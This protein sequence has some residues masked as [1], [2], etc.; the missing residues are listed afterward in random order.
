MGYM[1]CM[2]LSTP[3]ATNVVHLPPTF[4]DDTLSVA[5]S[6]VTITTTTTSSTSQGSD[7]AGDVG[8]TPTGGIRSSSVL[9][10]VKRLSVDIHRQRTAQSTP[11]TGIYYCT[12]TW[13]T[14]GLGVLGGGGAFNNVMGSSKSL[15]LSACNMHIQY[16]IICFLLH[17]YMYMYIHV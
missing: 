1:Y 11:S 15:Y 3:V 9:P 2:Q 8:A 10:V 16:V 13:P 17:I 7:L 12:Y 4:H 5:G 6:E 14:A